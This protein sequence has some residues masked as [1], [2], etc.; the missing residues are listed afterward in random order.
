MTG[1]GSY[2]CIATDRNEYAEPPGDSHYTYQTII[3]LIEGASVQRSTKPARGAASHIEVGDSAATHCRSP[4][5]RS[6]PFGDSTM[7]TKRKGGK[8]SNQLKDANS[9]HCEYSK[10]SLLCELFG[11]LVALPGHW[12]A[13]A[14]ACLLVKILSA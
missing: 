11:L 6:P 5:T 1:L 13:F 14:F 8:P 12:L 4:D 7:N 9:K 10:L 3:A 2:E